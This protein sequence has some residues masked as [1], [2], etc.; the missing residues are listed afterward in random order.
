MA[1]ALA[2]DDSKHATSMEEDDLIDR[3]TR[4]KRKELPDDASVNYLDEEDHEVLDGGTRRDDKESEMPDLPKSSF[5]DTLLNQH[6]GARDT[7]F[8]DDAMSEAS[9]E[10][11]DEG[12]ATCPRVKITPEE[13][14]RLR[15]PWRN[16]LILKLLGRLIGYSY[17]NVIALDN[18][19]FL[20]KFTSKQDYGH[21]LLGGPWMIA[22][23]KLSL[24]YWL[25]SQLLLVSTLHPRCTFPNLFLFLHVLV[26]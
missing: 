16:S 18:G 3:S 1:N 23:K 20:V 21:A 14:N 7:C 9:C 11:D 12:D 25:L 6:M 4:K 10:S 5:K 2:F 19:Y 17:F 13:K 8:D 22:M 24:L 15:Q 26:F